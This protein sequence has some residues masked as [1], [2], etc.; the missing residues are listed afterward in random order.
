MIFAP[1]YTYIDTDTHAHLHVC[2]HEWMSKI[3]HR[4]YAPNFIHS[5]QKHAVQEIKTLW[6]QSEV[7]NHKVV[8]V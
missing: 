6:L 8:S 4:F 5:Q 7:L 2:M 1:V 3:P